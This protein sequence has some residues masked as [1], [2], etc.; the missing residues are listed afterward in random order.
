MS[1]WDKFGGWVGKN[2]SVGSVS[3]AVSAEST[4]GVQ[5]AEDMTALLTVIIPT[6]IVHSNAPPNCVSSVIAVSDIVSWWPIPATLRKQL[7]CA[8][9]AEASPTINSS[10]RQRG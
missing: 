7:L 9:R 8:R 6:R 3:S 10:I 2:E 5:T 4:L 1:W